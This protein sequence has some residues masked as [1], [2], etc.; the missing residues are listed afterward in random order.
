M[1][2]LASFYNQAS[3]WTQQGICQHPLLIAE[4]LI[5]DKEGPKFQFP[6]GSDP[7]CLRASLGPRVN[8]REVRKR[9]LMK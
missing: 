2:Q 3:R 9:D 8:F 5:V 4:A 1:L 6:L 7:L